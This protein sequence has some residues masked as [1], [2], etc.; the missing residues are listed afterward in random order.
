ME[1]KTR[2]FIIKGAHCGDSQMRDV[3]ARRECLVG[4]LFEAI[5]GGPAGSVSGS[6]AGSAGPVS[7]RD[8]TGSV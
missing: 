1:T 4:V 5:S 6:N 8:P 2:Q 7:C 3:A